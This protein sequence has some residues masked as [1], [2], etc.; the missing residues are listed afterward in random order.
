MPQPAKN[1]IPNCIVY[2]YSLSLPPLCCYL[3]AEGHQHRNI[4]TSTPVKMDPLLF[5]KLV[6]ESPIPTPVADS[7]DSWPSLP[8]I[9][10]KKK[11]KSEKEKILRCP[12]GEG[13]LC[14]TQRTYQPHNVINCD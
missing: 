10:S 9:K 8:E 4:A 6:S 11:K 12:A 2:L 7:T 3:L 14:Q 1:A 13:D 5:D